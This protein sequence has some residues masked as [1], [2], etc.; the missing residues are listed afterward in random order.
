MQYVYYY[1]IVLNWVLNTVCT[2]F[3]FIGFFRSSLET[4]GNLG[5][6][7]EKLW[8]STWVQS[9][10]MENFGCSTHHYYVSADIFR[11]KHPKLYWYMSVY[12][13][14]EAQWSKNGKMVQEQMGV[15][16]IAWLITSKAKTNDFFW[17]KFFTFQ[18]P[19]GPL[20]SIFFF[21]KKLIF[22]FEAN[23]MPSLN[24]IFF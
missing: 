21:S 12:H 2:W 14:S 6:N 3:F 7:E 9:I 10:V 23:S 8:S 13:R 18:A 22:A 5:E 19:S 24:C 15:R 16:V 1:V 4:G 11:L 20:R 17:K